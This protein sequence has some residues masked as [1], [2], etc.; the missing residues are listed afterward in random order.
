VSGAAMI[1]NFEIPADD[2]E[3]AQAFY[4]GLFGWEIKEVPGRKDY[5]TITSTGENSVGGGLIKRFR[6][7]QT[8]INYIDVPSIDE[9][10]ARVE[11]LGGKI[12]VQRKPV[13]GSGYFAICRDTENNTFGMWEENNDAQ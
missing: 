10:S 8:I 5:F 13:R 12:V 1:V 4:S 11:A 3:R 2:L 6:P 7:Q 9:Y